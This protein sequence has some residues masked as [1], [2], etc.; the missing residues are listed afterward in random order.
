MILLELYISRTRK[1]TPSEH[2]FVF[3]LISVGGTASFPRLYVSDGHRPNLRHYHSTAPPCRGNHHRVLYVKW[4]IRSNEA[5]TT[6]VVLMILVSTSRRVTCLEEL[7]H[8]L[9]LGPSTRPDLRIH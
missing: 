5:C 3:Y 9:V 6:T 4:D 7:N 8:I 2:A 1:Q